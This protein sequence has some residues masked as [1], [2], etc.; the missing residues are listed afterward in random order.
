M[1]T[2]SGSSRATQVLPAHYRK[3]PTWRRQTAANCF[4]RVFKGNFDPISGCVA[5]DDRAAAGELLQ[6][7]FGS[8]RLSEVE[9]SL[10]ESSSCENT[11]ASDVVEQS[12][13]P[14]F[15]C[16]CPEDY[17]SENDHI[18][19]AKRFKHSN[20]YNVA[21]CLRQHMYCLSLV[22][23]FYLSHAMGALSV[24]SPSGHHTMDH[25][26]L[27][28]AFLGVD[29][30]HPVRYA[31]YHHLR[32]HG[33]VPRCGLKFGVEY[34]AYREGVGQY[35]SSYCVKVRDVSKACVMDAGPGWLE[36]TALQRVAEGAGKNLVVM[37]VVVPS[38]TTV[39]HPK[40]VQQFAI[41]ETLVRRWNY[42]RE[43]TTAAGSD[44]D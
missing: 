32:T 35:H 1:A 43:R 17:S 15:E 8:S 21:R 40:C 9:S 13:S 6:R 37:D 34:L 23:A 30:T 28:R 19:E 26:E 24:H 22:E 39:D 25:L 36:V 41:Q 33:W 27:W 3:K 4:P 10:E 38:N 18:P 14:A 11:R 12:H 42:T 5:V 20:K 2:L 29:G 44:V 31:A 7:G 16:E